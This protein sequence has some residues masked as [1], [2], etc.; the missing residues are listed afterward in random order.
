MGLRCREGSREQACKLHPAPVRTTSLIRC[1]PQRRGFVAQPTADLVAQRASTLRFFPSARFSPS[2]R[3]FL[4]GRGSRSSGT[5]SPR[6]GVWVRGETI[7]IGSTSLCR[8]ALGS[9]PRCSRCPNWS[10]RSQRSLAVSGDASSA[11]GAFCQRASSVRR[12][13]RCTATE[14]NCANGGK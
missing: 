14:R 7:H 6:E 8:T 1:D 4:R 12:P 10:F 9:A 2:P 11:N 5:L 13:Q 3:P